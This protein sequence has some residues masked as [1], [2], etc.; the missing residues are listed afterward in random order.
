MTRHIK[1]CA[2]A[3]IASLIESPG[4]LISSNMAQNHEFK[5]DSDEMRSEIYELHRRNMRK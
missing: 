4:D 3:T 2:E 1:A 5:A